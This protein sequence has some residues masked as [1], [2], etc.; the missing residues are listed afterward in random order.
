M[1]APGKHSG[2]SAPAL[3][4]WNG[5]L[6][7]YQSRFSTCPRTAVILEMRVLKFGGVES[8]SELKSESRSELKSEVLAEGW[9]HWEGS[10]GGNT[11]IAK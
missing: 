2:S 7:S 6:I 3:L 5:I 11:R 9:C 8:R 10:G 4:S 1:E